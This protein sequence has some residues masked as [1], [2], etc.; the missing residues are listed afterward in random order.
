MAVERETGA[1][2]GFYTLSAC[3]VFLEALPL[4]LRKGLPRYPAVPAA[5]LG[6]LAVD[7]RF[8]GLGLGGALVGDA[9]RRCAASEIAVNLLVVD[10]KDDGAARFYE[11]LGFRRP[12]ADALE[13]IASVATLSR[14]SSA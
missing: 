3:H 10:A 6:R 11:H 2:A 14:S 5:R 8:R 1:V 12:D 7:H 13:L 9:V 4:E